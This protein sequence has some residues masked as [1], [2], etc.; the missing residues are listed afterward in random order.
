MRGEGLYGRNE[1]R[2]YGYMSYLLLLLALGWPPSWRNTVRAVA[3]DG[4]D[5]A[6]R[7]PLRPY[8][9]RGDTCIAADTR[10]GKGVTVTATACRV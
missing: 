4:D 7:E 2:N 3:L 10:H 6:R 1:L 9:E 8:T 5:R